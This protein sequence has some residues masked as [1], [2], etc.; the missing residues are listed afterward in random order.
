MPGFGLTGGLRGDVLLIVVIDIC[1]VG[2]LEM[3][4]CVV[5]VL[6]GF[7]FWWRVYAGY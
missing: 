6:V 3:F 5:S 1:F 2:G 4:S 7:E